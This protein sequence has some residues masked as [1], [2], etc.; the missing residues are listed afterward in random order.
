VKKW[1][2]LGSFP[3]FQ[4][5]ARQRVPPAWLLIFGGMVVFSPLLEGGTTHTAAMIIR[6]L[7]LS[8]LGAYLWNAVRARQL[9]L[10]PFP[11]GPGVA[12]FLVLAAISAAVS[13]YRHQSVQWLIVLAGHAGALYLLV[14]LTTA[15]GQIAWLTLLLVGMGV[16]E[17]SLALHQAWVDGMARPTGTFANPNFLAGYLAAI[18]SI[19]L[20]ALVHVKI[21][22]RMGWTRIPPAWTASALAVSATVLPAI[23]LTRSRG[24]L[25]ALAAGAAVVVALR[26]GR[27]GLAALAV[28]FALAM[29]VP[30]PLSERFRAEHAVTNPIGYA[31]WQMWQGA[32]RQIVDYP[33]G[34]GLGLYQY[35]YPRYAFPIEGQVARYGKIAQ[36]PHS[37]YVQIGVELG[38][39]ALAVFG[40][41]IVRIVRELKILAVCRLR[42]WQRGVVT[43]AVGG[44]AS[45]LVH[46]AVDSNLHE[47]A[48]VVVLILCVAIL[49]STG[50][51][52]GAPV[53]GRIIPIRRPLL[54][55]GA[56]VL[57]V[58]LSAVLVMRMGVAWMAFEAG[59]RTL[60][61][62]HFERAA[63]YFDQAIELDPG[64]ALYHSSKAAAHFQL[65]QQTRGQGELAVV[66]SELKESIALNPL[67]AKP[68]KLLGDVCASAAAG[69]ADGDRRRSWL[70]QAGAA[71]EQ[72][73]ER[74][75]F[76]PFH[77]LELG[78][79]YLA[80]GDGDRAERLV[81]GAVELEPNFLPGRLW[82]AVRYARTD[83]TGPAKQEYEEI[84]KRQ[85]YY[86]HW[87]VEAYEGSFLNVDV[88]EL[89]A[90]VERPGDEKPRK[91]RAL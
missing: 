87:P 83:R 7:V 3:R 20:G 66:V 76:S 40:W 49:L 26:F 70:R 72:A 23:V 30:N 41:G 4:A 36:T 31:R 67:S 56:A 77:R 12:A 60:A 48:V 90:L 34:A 74:E 5:D 24:G 18:W 9:V 46:A 73:V 58:V 63:E 45:I 86:A 13:P 69:E 55:G 22:R 61:Q 52:A 84:L 37:E 42:R 89:A 8:V 38:A 64:K 62:R 35:L 91:H 81:L 2:P 21:G 6:L 15:W 32:G 59:S 39:L 82:L 19:C 10:R 17:A 28:A 78:R 47:P 88:R 71:Y 85:R 54:W 16:F 53:Q 68:F 65:F 25:L 51:L 33:F 50:R 27:R 29:V 80:L 1:I 75:P 79:L 43:G 57:V 11:I 14:S 44:M